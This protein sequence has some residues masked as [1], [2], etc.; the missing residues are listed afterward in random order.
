MSKVNYKL[1]FFQMV[2]AILVVFVHVP[3]SEFGFLLD[4]LGR[5]TVL[6]FFIVSGYFYSLSLD[7]PRFSYKKTFKKMLKLGLS[8][9]AIFIIYYLVS[10]IISLVRNGLP[11]SFFDIFIDL[12]PNLGFSW[13]LLS[14]TLCY[15]IYPLINKIKWLHTSKY[16]I[17][18]P[19]T[20]MVIVYLFRFIAGIYDLGIIGNVEVT[21]NTIFTGIPCFMIGTYLKDN[22]SRFKQINAK[23][24]IRYFL[25]FT[26]LII[27]EALL[28][29]QLGSIENEFYISSIFLCSLVVVYS[30]QNPQNKIGE[31]IEKT[32]YFKPQS[33]LYYSHCLVIS[34]MMMFLPRG[35]MF[36]LI[37]VG[38]GIIIPLV[39]IFLLN[40]IYSI[41]LNFLRV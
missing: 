37:V 8:F 6:F 35:L 31:Y 40:K 4:S 7:S 39:F 13:F 28:H 36:E 23:G 1:L 2:F 41:R 38:V 30:I 5:S 17:Y 21:R 33:F 15:L 3:F 11:S 14:L 19:L 9:L 16:S 24:F 12:H 22:I 32:Q 10:I 25:V 26:S 29:K 18:V 34:I 27:V 20:I